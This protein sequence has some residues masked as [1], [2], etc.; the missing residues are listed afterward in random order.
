[1]A[2]PPALIP[3]PAE[4]TPGQGVLRIHAGTPIRVAVG[5][6]DAAHT[7]RYFSE[8]VARTRGIELAERSGGSALR[9][10]TLKRQ[11]GLAAEAYRLTVTPRGATITASTDAGLFY[12]AVTL[13][14]LLPPGHG[15]VDI[16][17]L[18]IVDAPAYPWR[19]LM[20]DS[21]RHLQS[22]QFIRRM[23]D[24]MA[25][26]KLNV[27]HWH[28]TDDQGWR[29]EIRKYPRLCT[30]GA[31]RVPAALRPLTG[32]DTLGDRYGGCYTQG[33][34]RE[35]VAFAATRHVTIVPEIE[36]PGHAQAAIAAYPALGSLDGS[37]PPVS[38]KWGVHTYLYNLEP[39][40][41]TFLED[42]LSEVIELFPGRYVHIGGDEA[43]K[44]QW[45]AAATVQARA[46]VLGISD[47]DALQDYFTQHIGQ[48]LAAHGRRL[49]GWDEILRPELAADAIVMSWR[50][51][52]GAHAAAVA[53]NDTVL[54]P[55]PTLY[56]D[57]RQSGL[58]SEPPGR[59]RIVSLE[60]VYRF[61]LRDPSL[62]AEQQRHLLG[63]QGNLW[64]EHIRT[65]QRLEW[66]ALP[67]A[68]AI[69]ELGW[70]LPAR[71][72]WPDFVGRLAAFIPRY[73]ALGIHAADS[74]F[75]IDARITESASGVEVVFANQAGS[76][77]IRYTTDGR[78]PTVASHH[79]TNPFTVPPGT[80]IR[81]A[82]F[83]AGTQISATWSRNLQ[84]QPLARRSSRELELCSDGVGLLLEP[85]G[86]A[87]DTSTI[88][89][90]DIMNPCW[91]YRHADLTGGAHLSAAAVPLPFNFELGAQ[92][93]M[94]RRGDAHTPAGELEIR[95]DGCDSSPVAT[96]PLPLV[97]A[98][99]T[100]PA[101]ALAPIPGRHD[102]C[103][104][105]ARP[106]LEPMWA[107]DWVEVGE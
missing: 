70:S 86:A 12:G 44:D 80:Q 62:N 29:L 87:T 38:A 63:V 15:A 26:H 92:E 24:W 59:T 53:G 51:T 101:V 100:L 20:L 91:I 88:L 23:I 25:W 56:L 40:T 89:A 18:R 93:R 77:D 82:A 75:A 4:L 83:A 78:E 13:W 7:A 1:M 57:N 33:E 98:A 65:E 96:I 103:L 46:R 105:F 81:A 49:V 72:Q 54:T 16:P 17:T 41:F 2:A 104:R 58:S 52:T 61:E 69:A 19:G 95:I 84:Q 22:P 32:D 34:V 97:S 36:M 74:V 60:Q 67:R 43:V 11:P 47:A 45:R 106:S 21:A 28:L 31:W 99:A 66:M 94:I 10:I 107:L 90:L 76:G 8:L 42:V 85:P 6:S 39:A 37:P 102:L 30:V 55:W 5:D 50:G 35:I 64:T 3:Q 9:A 14:Q 79:Y 48:F 68:A 73:H 71:R 27:L